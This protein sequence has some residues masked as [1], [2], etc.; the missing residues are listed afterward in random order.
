MD[1]KGP[2][3][4]PHRRPIES[5]AAGVA[6]R[7]P[8]KQPLQTGIKAI[9]AMTPDRPGPARAHHRRPQDRQD[10]HR[11][12]HDH[13]P[14]RR[15]RDLR[16]RRLRADGR[17]RSPRWSKTCAAPG[18]WT[19]PSSSSRR[20]P[21]PAPLQYIAPY[22]GHGDGRIL[23]VRRGR[24][25]SACTTTCR[26]RRRRTGNVAA[27][28]PAAGP[29]GLP[30]RRVLLPQPAAR[31]VGQTRRPL[32]DRA[33][34]RTTGE[35]ADDWGINSAVDPTRKRHPGEA[36]KVYVGPSGKEE[37][38]Q[39]TEASSPAGSWPRGDL[40]RVADGPADH[41]DARRR[42][43]GLHPDQRDLDHRRADLSAAVAVLRG[44]AAGRG[45]GHLGRRVSAA[46]P[47]SRP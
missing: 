13:Q 12:R 37:A 5:P 19:T 29:R 45:R 41:R 15:E 24:T 1:G 34:T 2:I 14:E 8:V 6:D 27:A 11:P 36:G 31:A 43:V 25:P 42:S 9:D 23:H 17:R 10:G 7:Q 35:I 30:R 39:L 3:V 20:R 28:A 26:S 38:E 16:L 18:R 22:A 21:T 46:T 47:R 33:R 32:G 44:R 4:T 40:G